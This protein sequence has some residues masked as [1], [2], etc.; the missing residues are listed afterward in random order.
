[1][2]ANSGGQVQ[3]TVG[4]LKESGSN[5]A[6]SMS[7][8]EPIDPE[9]AAFERANAE[10]R[11]AEV[12]SLP[13]TVVHN[14]R[15]VD[16]EGLSVTEIQALLEQMP[17]GLKDYTIKEGTTTYTA[18][19][20]LSN[21]RTG[22][23]YTTNPKVLLTLLEMSSGLVM[24]SKS[25][26]S[27]FDAAPGDKFEMGIELGEQLSWLSGQLAE[28]YLNIPAESSVRTTHEAGSVAVA[29]VLATLR[30][31]LGDQQQAVAIPDQFVQTY[32]EMFGVD[33]REAIQIP[34]LQVEPFLRKPFSDQYGD[35]TTLFGAVNSLFDHN[36]PISTTV[37]SQLTLFTGDS[38]AG[39]L[40]SCTLGVSCY[41]GHSAIDFN[42]NYGDIHPAHS[43]TVLTACD[44]TE[45]GCNGG[46]G[47]F[48]VVQGSSGYRTLYG[49]LSAIGLNP[50]SGATPAQQRP[51]R[52]G[53][54][55]SPSDILGQSGNTGIGSFG[56]HL[57]FE[58]FAGGKTVDPFGWWKA[59]TTSEDPWE[60]DTRGTASTWLWYTGSVTDE[61]QTGFERFT[62]SSCAHSQ[63]S[64][65]RQ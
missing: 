53:D 35:G 10:P 47:N 45:T 62:H 15:F 64:R 61:K 7:A 42:T 33:P 54:S 52:E 39:T 5:S 22:E 43:G 30:P 38:T 36:L 37:D 16:A 24:D 51:W 1:M 29:E 18:A 63:P 14:T 6:V 13:A 60:K 49:H 26:P 40:H 19:Q 23:G 12:Q 17:G 28:E 20:L 56:A 11:K 4:E 50:R 2:P 58:T 46:L 3:F 57:H 48:L 34:T 8:Q 55:V 59:G 31:A 21:A 27:Q 9:I 32:Q 44:E 25:E 41:D 65:L